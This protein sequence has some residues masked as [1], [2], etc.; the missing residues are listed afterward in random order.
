M[1]YLTIESGRVITAVDNEMKKLQETSVLKRILLE[2]ENAETVKSHE[3]M[4]TKALAQ[5]Q[6]SEAY[7]DE[8]LAY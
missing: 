5:V 2:K 3:E 6:V 8:Y 1:D 7:P 4:V